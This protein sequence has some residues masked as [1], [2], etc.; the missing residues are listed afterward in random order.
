VVRF[1]P[2]D[3]KV[4][5]SLP[6][7]VTIYQGT[8][9]IRF[10]TWTHNIEVG[11]DLYAPWPG[12]DITGIQFPSDGTPANADVVLMALPGSAI[13][14]GDAT[15]GLL[16]N[17][18]ITI[19]LFDTTD[20]GA[21]T[22]T[23]LSGTI[24]SCNEDSLGRVTI[25]ANG[26]LRLAAEYAINEKYSLTGRETLGDDRCKI[27][28]CLAPDIA[29]Y[30]IGRSQ[31]YVPRLFNDGSTG[32]IQVRDCYGRGRSGTAGDVE[33]YANVYY[34]A[35]NEGTTGATAPTFPSSVGSVFSDGG[36]Q[37][38]ARNAWA[39]H[40]RGYAQDPFN[41]KLTA[42]PDSR[43]TDPT[44]Y[45]LG[46]IF[47]RSGKYSGFPGFVISAWDPVNFIATTFL[48]IEPDFVPANSQ[49]EIRPGCD[50]TYQMCYARFNNILNIRAEYMVP[51]ASI[52]AKL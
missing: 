18:P 8:V 48:P 35:L 6:A 14:S 38:I 7:L 9:I 47:I 45:A 11:S 41:I 3:P 17:W 22:F 2:F 31:A 27:P 40:A 30:D 50:L 10:T 5:G 43:A 36:V 24:G 29:G 34:E 26:Q 42:L 12:S 46:A 28:I 44:W 32:L 20:L 19:E 51:P 1:F 39:R 4:A 16:D 23:L 49:F 33:D 21:G 25:A 15:K 52:V 37:F 13:Q